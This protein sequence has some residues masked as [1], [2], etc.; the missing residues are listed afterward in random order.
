[1]CLF[2]CVCVS[3]VVITRRL[4]SVQ[5]YAPIARMFTSIAAHKHNRNRTPTPTAPAH[6]LL[7][8]RLG[9]VVGF[10][11]QGVAAVGA[12]GAFFLQLAHLLN[13]FDLP[14]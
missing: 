3:R 8:C 9:H 2:T 13:T 7:C 6:P 12:A 10:E 4:L 11:F 14:W 1:M 5:A